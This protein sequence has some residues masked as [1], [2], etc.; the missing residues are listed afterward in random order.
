L[1]IDALLSINLIV[2]IYLSPVTVKG[3]LRG[4]GVKVNFDYGSLIRGWARFYEKDR[5]LYVEL[6]VDEVL[7]HHF[8]KPKTIR[9]LH[10]PNV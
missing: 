2:L 4:D 3:S 10:I 9:L 1:E 5:Y 7:G 6:F 8:P